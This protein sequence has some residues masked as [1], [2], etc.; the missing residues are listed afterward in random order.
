MGNISQLPT[1]KAGANASTP[2]SLKPPRGLSA[3]ARKLWHSARATHAIDDAVSLA[4]LAQ[5]CAEHDRSNA[6]DAV[7][8]REGLTVVDPMNHRT[9]P[10]P[11]IRVGADARR[12]FLSIVKTLR[13]DLTQ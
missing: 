5:L 10:H 1:A 12:M 7:V 11:L 3:S 13:L 6:C 8:A 9:V 4:L 2:A